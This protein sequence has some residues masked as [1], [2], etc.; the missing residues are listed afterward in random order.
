MHAN[1][2]SFDC[3]RSATLNEKRICV[4][5]TL[6][7]LDDDMAVL[8]RKLVSTMGDTLKSQQVL[9]VKI[10]RACRDE[11]CLIS[12]YE[13]RINELAD[14]L[15]SIIRSENL[16]K[17]IQVIVSNWS[18][19][20]ALCRSSQLPATDVKACGERESLSSILEARGWCFGNGT[21]IEAEYDK[22]WQ[23]CKR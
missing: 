4:N 11:A 2:A 20:N 21:S 14:E 16:P 3:S 19:S 5:P 1:G 22:I 8:Y 12:V 13:S 6:S 18:S 17:D 9:W 23:K 10:Q 7:K 15:N